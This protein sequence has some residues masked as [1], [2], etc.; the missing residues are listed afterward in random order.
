MDNDINYQKSTHRRI[1]TEWGILKED[2]TG[3]EST[4]N[5]IQRKEQSLFSIDSQ[6]DNLEE[7]QKVLLVKHVEILGRE[8]VKPIKGSRMVVSNQEIDSNYVPKQR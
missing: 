6:I 3:T 7:M 1:Y 8:Y 5:A 4:A 2:S